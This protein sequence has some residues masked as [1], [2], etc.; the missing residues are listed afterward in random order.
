MR[1]LVIFTIKQQ[2]SIRGSRYLYSNPM[3]TV[4]QPQPASINT[5]AL[6]WTIG[7][8]ILI[9]LLCLLVKY[10]A[11]PEAPPVEELGM[12][13]NLGTSE[14]GWGLDQPEEPGDPAETTPTIASL[15][16]GATADDFDP[17]RADEVDAPEIPPTTAASRNPRVQQPSP[18]N[19]A[20]RT[21]RPTERVAAPAATPPRNPR[22]VY[23]GSTGP[24]GNGGQTTTPGGSEGNTT[25][26]GDRGVPG[27]TPGASNYEGSPGRGTGGI[28]HNLSGR[29]VIAPPLEAAFR[30]GGKVYVRVTV[31]RSGK[32]LSSSIKAPSAELRRITE[33][34]LRQV[35]FNAAPDAPEEQFGTITF[36]FKT[37]S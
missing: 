18:N 9:L 15:A 19:R 7:I 30:E 27:G 2:I 3:T 11:P 36:V 35:R 34:K 16:S 23:P 20:A 4:A 22:Y 28:G 26:P 29:R 1:E 33:E 17:V 32:I 6:A 21:D 31:D 13:V 5:R 12:E 24:G 8:H 10:S 25:G 37:R 14:D